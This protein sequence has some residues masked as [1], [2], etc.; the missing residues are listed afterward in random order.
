LNEL[1]GD[2]RLSAADRL[3]Y[4]WRNGR[5]GLGDCVATQLSELRHWPANA[6]A[7]QALVSA[8]PSP[9][10]ALSEAFIIEQL[11]K[12][13]PPGEINVLEVGCGSGRARE[14]L[15]RAGFHGTYTGVDISDRFDTG[16]DTPFASTFE[17]M[18]AH[19]LEPG[20]RFDLIFS[21]SAL[22]HIPDDARLIAH[23]R[24]TLRP[25]GLQLHII[26]SGA[27]LYA[28]LWHGY[29]Q[30]ARGGVAA[31][32]IPDRTA[33]YG[34]GGMFSL[35]LHVA[36]ITVP[37]MLLRLPARRK[38]AALYRL[39]ARGALVADRFM[40]FGAVMYGVCERAPDDNE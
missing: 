14:L 10:R 5:R 22:E 24:T 19:N 35:V 4:L 29:R 31:R 15:A 16:R 38:V 1:N 17:L 13:L 12:L 27:A 21:N 36:F 18:D 7:R 34:L 26:P 28:Y 23:L 25:G 30:Y 33:V 6:V 39:C 3:R 8:S 40:P 11:P 20:A 32:F 2:T 37:E 9:G